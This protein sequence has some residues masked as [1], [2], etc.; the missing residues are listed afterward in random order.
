MRISANIATNLAL[1]NQ[2]CEVA[3]KRTSASGY[4]SSQHS[5]IPALAVPGGGGSGEAI[6]RQ[7]SACMKA[8]QGT[9][10]ALL[11]A[12]KTFAETGLASDRGKCGVF[13]RPL[14][15]TLQA[16]VEYTS[17]PEF[18]GKPASLS[19][20][21]RGRQK[22]VLASAM[23]T[24]SAAIQLMQGMA[25]VLKAADDTQP[26]AATADARKADWKHIQVCTVAL[27][28]ASRTLSA[29][30]RNNAP[31]RQQPPPGQ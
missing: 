23:K 6:R 22:D 8:I 20:L 28:E 10:A 11:A 25:R 24:V 18:T 1:V 27:S 15:G 9:T 31:G 2:A 26:A 12:L 13:M 7:L 4:T 30:M 5:V 29:A 3:T 19:A 14:L 16:L 21:A 17:L